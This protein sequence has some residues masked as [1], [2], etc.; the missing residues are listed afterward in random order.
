[1]SLK[2]SILTNIASQ[3]ASSGTNLL[4]GV[5][6]A[7]TLTLEDFGLYGVGFSA[8]LFI[9][10][11]VNSSVLIN[12]SIKIPQ[13]EQ[14]NKKQYAA[15]TF[16]LLLIILTAITSAS[17]ITIKTLS[18]HIEIINNNKSIIYATTITA[19]LYLTK[20]FFLRYAYSLFNELLAFKINLASAISTVALIS[21]TET[22]N[23][24]ANSTYAIYILGLGLGSGTII[25]S[26]YSKLSLRDSKRTNIIKIIIDS[27]THGRWGITANIINWGRTQAYAFLSLSLSGAKGVATLNAARI[28]MTPAIFLMPPI[29]QIMLPRLA[30]LASK[31]RKKAATTGILIALTLFI[32]CIIYST[33]VLA[34]INPLTEIAL[35]SNYKDI[36]PAT[37]A[38]IIFLSLSTITTCSTLTLQALKEF[39]IITHASFLSAA[40]MLTAIYPLNSSIG[41]PGIVYSMAIGEL[42]MAIITT[43]RI[44]KIRKNN[45]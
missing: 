25:G 43:A 39:P 22:L 20:D 12:M 18:P 6:F 27:W 3:A 36:M 28:L 35:G 10:G 16:L 24:K 44:L 30:A 5:Y 17:F 37:L 7:R 9:G 21:L 8:C 19:C 34:L 2:K 26:I 1:M 41:T 4:L 15:D 13:L 42:A 14:E 11:V 29:G 40:T 32:F 45:A 33:A 38:W 31:D 23:I